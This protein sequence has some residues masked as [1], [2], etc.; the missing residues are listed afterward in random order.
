MLSRASAKSSQIGEWGKSNSNLAGCFCST[1]SFPGSVLLCRTSQLCIIWNMCYLH[2]NSGSFIS[3]CD[4]HDFFSNFS[5]FLHYHTVLLLVFNLYLLPPGIST[6]TGTFG[7]SF[8]DIAN[9]LCFLHP[10]DYPVILYYCD[11]YFIKCSLSEHTPTTW[12]ME[13]CQHII[14]LE[15]CSLLRIVFMLPLF[16]VRSLCLLSDIWITRLEH[17]NVPRMF[18]GL[19]YLEK[20]IA[21]ILQEQNVYQRKRWYKI[22]I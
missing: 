13:H 10:P 3:V 21:A 22:L 6:E 17:L 7:G 4:F 1:L 5:L 11:G 2:S 19:K 12:E 8:L 18:Q 16:L 15:K 9:A 14:P 20:K